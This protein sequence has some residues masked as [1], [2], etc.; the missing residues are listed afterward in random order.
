[1]LKGDE[2]LG[3]TGEELGVDRDEARKITGGMNGRLG[4]LD[5]TP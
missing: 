5:F 2:E 4:N 3:T 1:M